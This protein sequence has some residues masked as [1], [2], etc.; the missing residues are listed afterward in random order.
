M[1]SHHT[2]VA[3][4]DAASP[5]SCTEAEARLGVAGDVALALT[6][7]VP[8]GARRAPLVLAHGFGQSRAAWERSSRLLSARGHASTRFDARGHGDSDRNPRD[9][10]YRGEQF[11][12]DL[13]AV[14]AAAGPRPVLVGASMG[15]LL[16]LLAQA[17]ET[18]FSALVLVDITPRWEDAGVRRILDF[19]GAHPEG[20]DSLEHAADE[21]ARYLPHRGS[22]KS[23][24]QLR[25]LLRPDGA[26]RWRWHWDP[27]LLDEF[28]RDSH[29]HQ[30]R[31]MEAARTVEVP[32]LLVSGGRSDL[33]S[34]ETVSEFLQL[35]P[36]ASHVRLPEATHMVAGDDNDA[37]TASVMD[38]L[39][40][41]GGPNPMPPETGV[42]R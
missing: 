36:H 27:R 35:V 26:G 39:A 24:G 2:P 42:S 17:R 38:F 20:F 41:H 25:Q 10:P 1:V 18:C 32:V 23:P 6:H 7:R 5:P 29:Q 28:A 40:E 12:D 4:V 8:G 34:A 11:V 16:G 37:F 13:V 30:D 15:G 19:M 33:V 21:I 14:A 31:M 9:L 22:R 3:S